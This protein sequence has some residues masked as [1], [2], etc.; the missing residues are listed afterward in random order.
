M[1]YV[2]LSVIFVVGLVV[3]SLADAGPFA[4]IIWATGLFIAI[5][6]PA[7]IL[8]DRDIGRQDRRSVVGVLRIIRGTRWAP[9]H[10][11]LMATRTTR[12][13]AA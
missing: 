6:V 3:M 12:Q 10:P 8:A 11:R 5:G 1:K 9:T 7:L 2:I 4:G 13:R